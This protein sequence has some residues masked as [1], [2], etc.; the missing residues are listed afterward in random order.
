MP[1]KQNQQKRHKVR[2]SEREKLRSH[3]ANTELARR[4]KGTLKGSCTL[5]HINQPLL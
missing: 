5:S 1:N 3:L 2:A 4:I